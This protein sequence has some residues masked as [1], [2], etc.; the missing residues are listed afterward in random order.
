MSTAFLIVGF[1]LL[2]VGVGLWSL[3][4]AFTVAGLLLFIAGG[5]DL[6]RGRRTASK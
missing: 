4:A 5:L 6:T 2:V 1:L 3:P